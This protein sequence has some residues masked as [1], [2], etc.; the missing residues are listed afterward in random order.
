MSGSG[1][2]ASSPGRSEVMPPAQ[3]AGL[4]QTVRKPAAMNGIMWS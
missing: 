3:A 1:G 4:A 2:A